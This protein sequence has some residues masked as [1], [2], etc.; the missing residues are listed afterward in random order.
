[1]KISILRITYLISCFTL[2]ISCH[3][4]NTVETT[5]T[6]NSG[7]KYDLIKIGNQTWIASY[8]IGTKYS[9][10]DPIPNL[11]D[12][13]SWTNTV[14]GAYC[15]YNNDSINA[16]TYGLNY[17]Y[18]TV[19][20]PRG[21]APAGF[22]VATLEDWQELID[23]LGGLSV[24]GGKL[25]DVN[26]TSWNQPNVGA[27]NE[28][29][30]NIKGGGYRDRNCVFGVLKLEVGYWADTRNSIVNPAYVHLYANSEKL[31]IDITNPGQ[32]GSGEHI[33]LI[34]NK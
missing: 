32:Q 25:K 7:N 5:L 27:T 6:D 10:G 4:E 18:Y 17:N 2:F 22:H 9:N 1:M 28:A 14:N 21:L 24:A 31:T 33:R 23:F 34:K 3:E 19:T 15:Y 8:F 29:K 20:D 13:S 16:H 30:F 11:K 26:N 12:C